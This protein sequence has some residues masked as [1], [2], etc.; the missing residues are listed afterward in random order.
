MKS[1]DGYLEIRLAR[2]AGDLLASQ[3]L[4]YRVFVQEMGADGPDV[5][6]DAGLERDVMDAYF[7]HLILVDKRRDEAA[8]DHVVGVYRILDRAGSARAGG[9]YSQGEYDLSPLLNGGR[10]LLELGRSCVD[11]DYRNGIALYRLW[12][13]LGSYVSENEIDILFGVASFPGTDIDALRLPLTYLHQ[14]HL[15]PSDLRVVAKEAA[16]APDPDAKIDRQAALRSIPPLIKSY[17]RIG[18]FVGQG[19]F[20]DRVF[21]T[22]DVCMIL[23]TERMSIAQKTRYAPAGEP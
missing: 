6:H 23:D 12:H 20:V 9:F 17:L 5:D 8:M 14:H 10:S 4:R 22:V 2:N 1:D 19:A 3:R 13:G 18:G 11:A 21:N 7:Q 16:F 15:A